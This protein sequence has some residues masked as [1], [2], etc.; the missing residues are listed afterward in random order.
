AEGDGKWIAYAALA[1]VSFFWGTTYLG[2]RMSLES[3]PPL[4]LIAIRYT[5]SGG[6]LLIVAKLVGARMPGRREFAETSLF[7]IISIGLGNCALLRR[8][9]DSQRHGVAVH[10]YV[11]VLDGGD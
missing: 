6:L 4:Y 9:V 1:A 5:L 11:A 2:I 3:F 7:G 10:L 8:G